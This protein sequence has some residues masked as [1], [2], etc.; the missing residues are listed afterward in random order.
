MARIY[1]DINKYINKAEYMALDKYNVD[2]EVTIGLVPYKE[3]SYKYDSGYGAYCC[4]LIMDTDEMPETFKIS[5]NFVTQ[6]YIGQTYKAKGKIYIY[7]RKKQLKVESIEKIKPKTPRT[8]KLFLKS[9]SEMGP[10]A[11][12]IYEEYGENALD[13]I[14]NNPLKLKEVAPA[15]YDNLALSWQ[16]QLIEMNDSQEYLTVLINYG[17]KPIQAKHFFDIHK[18]LCVQRI[19]ENPYRLMSELEGFGFLKCDNI[20]KNIGYPLDSEQR[21]NEALLYVLKATKYDGNTYMKKDELIEKTSDL[22]A[23]KLPINDMKKICK[24][25]A[26][27]KEIVY[28]VGNLSFVIDTKD[29]FDAMKEYSNARYK[30]DKEEAKL[31]VFNIEK[32]K[33]NFQIEFLKVEK[34]IVIDSSKK[35]IKIYDKNLYMDE[36]YIAHKL[37]NIEKNNKMIEN[38][39]V[40]ELLDVYLYKN[41]IQL[42]EQQYNAVLNSAKSLGGFSIIDGSA[43]CGKTFTLNV[44]LAII[45]KIYEN[46]FGYFEVTILAPTG[47]A[48]KVAQI[49][50]KRSASTIHKALKTKED[51]KFFYNAQNN[52]PY[53]CIVCDEASMLDVEM[54]RYLFEAIANKTKVI[55]IGDTKQLASVGAGN[56]LKDII[57]S[58]KFN[59]TTLNVAKRQALDSGIYKNA[60][61]IINKDMISS[62]KETRDAFVYKALNNEKSLEK[63]L[64]LYDNLINQLSLDQ[65]QVLAPQKSGLLGTN[66]LNFILQERYNEKSEGIKILNKQISVRLNN[67]ETGKYEL[68][69]KKGDKVIHTENDYKLS[70]YQLSKGKLILDKT[71]IGISNGETGRIVSILQTKDENRNTINRIVVKYE[72]KY[73][74]YTKDFSQLDHAYAMTIHKSQGSEWPAVIIPI[75]FSSYMMLENNLIYTGYTRAK[76]WIA[77]VGDPEAMEYAINNEKSN[78]RQTG[79][80]DRILEMFS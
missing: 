42:E 68:Y 50:T 80:K 25:A 78:E 53:N 47:R 63:I 62:E 41:Q 29:I 10:F 55:F 23:I 11:D 46:I 74:I 19:K 5:G 36:A 75:T 77:V 43:G 6:L 33:I 34:K 32:E 54:A 26:D 15:I 44:A 61:R 65:I 20:A 57:N 70:W 4:E 79:L 58:N 39:N 69:F 48:A 52:L 8:I 21:I 56:V 9:L 38:I 67:N 66:Y 71:G 64:D 45:E 3:I 49:A 22:L 31:I 28:K 1:T 76:K 16:K 13:V 60:K 40:E 14:K 73:I 12:L 30:K 7:D 27:K 18:E 35:P 17:L 37:Y 2:E 59:V 24:Q 72:D 51:G